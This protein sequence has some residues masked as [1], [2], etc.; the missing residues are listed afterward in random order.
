MHHRIIHNF[1]THARTKITKIINARRHRFQN[2]PCHGFG[3]IIA[4]DEKSH[5]SGRH[6]GHTASNGRINKPNIFCGRQ[7]SAINRSLRRNRTGLNQQLWPD[8]LCH[9]LCCHRN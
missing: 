6:A 4:A 5:L 3:H 2:R 8:W 1:N 9:D 7:G